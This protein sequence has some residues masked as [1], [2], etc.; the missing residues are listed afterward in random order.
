MG[1]V[2]NNLIDLKLFA[3]KGMPRHR[4]SVTINGRNTLAWNLTSIDIANRPTRTVIA[5][6]NPRDILAVLSHDIQNN[7]A[8]YNEAIS[9]LKAEW[10]FGAIAT[11]KRVIREHRDSQIRLL[12][13]I[14]LETICYRHGAI[15]AL[16]VGEVDDVGGN[17]RTI[18]LLPAPFERRGLH[19][20]TDEEKWEL[21]ES[22]NM[23]LP[24]ML[25]Q[26]YENMANYLMVIFFGAGDEHVLKYCLRVR[27][28]IE[29][30]IVPKLQLIEQCPANFPK[31]YGLSLRLKT[32]YET[33]MREAAGVSDFVHLLVNY[34]YR[35]FCI[36]DRID[37]EKGYAAR[38]AALEP[39]IGLL[40]DSY[41]SVPFLKKCAQYL[42]DPSQFDHFL[43]ELDVGRNSRPNWLQALGEVSALVA[44]IA[45]FTAGKPIDI[46]HIFISHH[47]RV[48]ESERFYETM[49]CKAES[50]QH[51]TAIT[52]RE[53]SK[54]LRW[55]VLARIWFCDHQVFFLPASTAKSDGQFKR[56]TKPKEDWVTLELLY[57]QFVDR[58]QTFIVGTP[59]SEQH[60]EE[61]RRHLTDY[62]EE[63]EIRQIDD[64]VW[65]GFVR[66]AKWRLNEYL[67]NRKFLL[68]NANDFTIGC[69][70]IDQDVIKRSAR[71][72]METLCMAWCYFFNSDDW[73]IAQALIELNKSVKIQHISEFIQDKA[74]NGDYR[75]K[76]AIRLPEDKLKEAVRRSTKKVGE[77]GFMIAGQ[78]FQPINIWRYRS[79]ITVR[80]RCTELLITLADQFGIALDEDVTSRI[81]RIWQER[82]PD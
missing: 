10:H 82:P 47:F 23:F 81:H 33:E 45:R 25:T 28:I 56:L 54:H 18:V 62:T 39:D 3:Q 1:S 78:E 13:D 9:G 70:D 79:R 60:I 76:W 6:E 36:K 19:V 22:L 31:S 15:P 8:Q 38:L 64:V 40:E 71:D 29:Q 63:K 43:H 12:P 77:F 4:L 65:N 46:P 41:S 35:F 20:S 69:D 55:S 50:H 14:P 48:I 26:Y 53:L 27:Q 32:K 42:A 37:G 66:P 21:L 16:V 61:Y 80:V 51:F 30:S 73:S 17:P 34:V 44:E 11:L 49:K 52:G 24:H 67:H 68:C 75:F 59:L 58:R 72:L 74:H 7:W 5:F 57:G 2:R